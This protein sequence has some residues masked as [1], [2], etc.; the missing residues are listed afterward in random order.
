MALRHLLILAL[1]PLALASV[2]QNVTEL[3]KLF[4]KFEIDFG[5]RY[6]NA[7]EKSLRFINFVRNYQEMEKHNK[8]QKIFQGL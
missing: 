3:N 6:R 1:V 7:E 4:Q 5:K 8:V 2:T